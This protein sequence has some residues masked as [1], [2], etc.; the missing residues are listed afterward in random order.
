VPILLSPN[1]IKQR[2]TIVPEPPFFC[3]SSVAEGKQKTI[4][5]FKSFNHKLK[6]V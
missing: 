6:M 3:L 1:Q 2:I 5:F 4:P